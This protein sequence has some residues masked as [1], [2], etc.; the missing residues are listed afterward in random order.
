MMAKDKTPKPETPTVEETPVTDP[1][2]EVETFDDV[3]TVRDPVPEE[4]T[5]D[6]VPTVEDTPVNDY[7]HVVTTV[8]YQHD[9]PEVGELDPNRLYEVKPISNREAA[10][11]LREKHQ[12]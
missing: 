5:F 10:R 7:V 8:E 1:A 11:L 2:P 6:D 4:E 3:P 12:G 9:T